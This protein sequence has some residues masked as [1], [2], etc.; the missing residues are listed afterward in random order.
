LVAFI[1]ATYLDFGVVGFTASS[2]ARNWRGY[3]L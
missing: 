2:L 1:H 3:R